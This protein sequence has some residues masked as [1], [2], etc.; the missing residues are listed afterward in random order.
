MIAK[1][2]HSRNFGIGIVFG[3]AYALGNE[4]VRSVAIGAIILSATWWCLTVG[5]Q[6]LR[7]S[8]S[9]GA[10]IQQL[11]AGGQP[12]VVPTSLTPRTTNA[13]ATKWACVLAIA[14]AIALT[15]HAVQIIAGLLLIIP[16][17][18]IVDGIIY[19]RLKSRLRR[20]QGYAKVLGRVTSAAA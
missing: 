19:L 4:F 13:L 12:V 9:I 7:L 2:V 1:R 6:F 18:L 14:M 5:W 11:E 17:L 15:G 16:A 3:V 20:L 8:R 10:S